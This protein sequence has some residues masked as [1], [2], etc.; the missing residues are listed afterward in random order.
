MNRCLEKREGLRTLV[1]PLNAG[2][3][4]T[5]RRGNDCLIPSPIPDPARCTPTR[6][7]VGSKN[8]KKACVC[9]GAKI[10][11]C[12]G[13]RVS[14]NMRRCGFTFCLFGIFSLLLLFFD[15]WIWESVLVYCE[16]RGFA[17]FVQCFNF[18]FCLLCSVCYST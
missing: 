12:S 10:D 15:G 1:P 3:V 2:P 8:G 5:T 13:L 11:L 16:R 18:Y 6:K 9:E 17:V 14:M 4:N 7:K